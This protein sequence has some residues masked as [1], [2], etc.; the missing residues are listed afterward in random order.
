VRKPEKAE[1]VQEIQGKA[2]KSKIGILTDFT[3]LK[4]EDMTR[5]RRQIQESQGELTVVKNTLLRRAAEGDSPL[6]PL[7]P[8]FTGPN[9]ITLGYDDPVALTKVMMKFAQEKPLLKIKAGVLSGQVLSLKDLEALS[10]LPAREVLMAQLLG[11]LQGVPTGLVRV[12]AGVIRNLMNVLVAYRDQKAESEGG[13][14]AAEAEPEAV[15]AAEPEA[16]AAAT[17]EA[18]PTAEPEAAPAAEAEAAPAAA[19]E[20]TP[21]E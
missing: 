2:Q 7:T 4:V 6:A 21:K 19:A 8:Q 13:S 15:A 20:E 12:L 16:V 1:I 3:G 17:P 5:L 10:K 14:A 11:V 9:A 18:A